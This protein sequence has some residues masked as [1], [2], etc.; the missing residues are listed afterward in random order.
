M[1]DRRPVARTLV[2]NWARDDSDL[3]K[4][5]AFHLSNVADAQPS[6]FLIVSGSSTPVDRVFAFG[7]GPTA[8]VPFPIQI[9]EVSQ[10]DLEKKQTD[11]GFLPAGWRLDQADELRPDR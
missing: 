2:N 3:V 10:E 8:D 6:E 11:Q 9:A 1:T 4:V 5:Y 7:F